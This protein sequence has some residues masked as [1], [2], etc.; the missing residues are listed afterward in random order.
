[1]SNQT[2]SWQRAEGLL[3]LVAATALFHHLGGAWL[4]FALLFFVP[5]ASMLG[6]LLG[7]ARGA[8]IYNTFHN[9]ALPL[10]L[11]TLGLVLNSPTMQLGALIWSAHIGFDRALGYGLKLPTSFGDTHMGA[12]KGARR[13]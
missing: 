11:G 3:A 4:V 10:A 7:A 9:Y 13:A 6:Y 1:M 2:V 12:L 5:D 8:T